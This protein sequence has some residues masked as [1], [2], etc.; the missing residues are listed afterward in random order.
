MKIRFPHHHLILLLASCLAISASADASILLT[1]TELS[2]GKT[3]WQMTTSETPYVVGQFSPTG[4]YFEEIVLPQNAFD[5]DYSAPF[6]ISFPA[7]IGRI[8]NV[9]TGATI[10]LTGIRYSSV[11]GLRFDGGLMSHALGNSFEIVDLPA[12][13]VNVLFSDVL[14]TGS[15]AYSVNGAWHQVGQVEVTAVPIPEPA[16]PLMALFG[17]LIFCGF[18]RRRTG[19]Y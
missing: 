12:I 2:D 16:A 6:A 11:G 13:N 14:T 4:N 7:P 10:D 5:F 9:T 3:K 19:A 1:I 17:G 18:I 15:T 8:R